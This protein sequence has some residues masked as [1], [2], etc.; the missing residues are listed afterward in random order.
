MKH[1][2]IFTVICYVFGAFVSWEPN[3]ANW[4]MPMRALVGML[5]IVFGA[6]GIADDR[7]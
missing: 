5:V 1:A 7:L 6:L 4:E 2:I 3:P